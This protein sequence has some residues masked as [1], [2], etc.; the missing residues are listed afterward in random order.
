ME[1]NELQI[2]DW[3]N[4]NGANVK[5]VGID[6]FGQVTIVDSNDDVYSSSV[7]EFAPIPLTTDILKNIGFGYVENTTNPYD[8]EVLS[9]FY[10]GEEVY[11]ANMDI[12]IGTY[13]NGVF[14]F[15]SP[16]VSL[17]GFRYVHEL[18]HV[19]KLGNI[20]IDLKL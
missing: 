12:H 8:N 7:K 17:N 14:W 3:L 16:K 19:L 11:C 4:I 15:S 20:N 2:G 10:L 6:M 9:H 1:T 5:I 18:Q 13:N